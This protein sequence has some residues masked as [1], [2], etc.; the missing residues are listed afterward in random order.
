MEL[1]HLRYFVAV[2]Q[3]GTFSQTA[4]A[5]YVSQSTISEQLADLEQE[6]G[7]PLFD[8]RERRVRLTQHGELFLVEARKVL[9]ASDH[10]M[11]VARQSLKGEIGNL[12]IA[13]FAGGVE[14]QFPELI[15][16]FRMLHPKIRVTLTELTPA[17]QTEALLEGTIDVG[18][19][20]RLEPS[21]ARHLRSEALHPH[22]LVAVLPPEH[23][24][25]PGAIN[26]RAL[27]KERFVFCARETS[28]VLF[29]KVIALCSE[30]G[31][32]PNI[33]GIASVWSGVVM[34]VEAG[35]GVAILPDLQQLRSSN[36]SF[37]PLTAKDAY[38]DL[39]MAWSTLRE[40]TVLKA[41][42]KLVRARKTHL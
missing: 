26:I 15:R 10:A 42:L 19:T 20:R 38:V 14:A 7:V 22:R 12:R 4:R 31:F 13:F 40:D 11:Q 21:S 8:R 30:A 28:P 33:V 9:A 3:H 17:E 34:L 32:S 2:A 1:R 23:H 36:L 39:V 18:F 29:D 37:C 5:V 24:L 25:R 6:L 16:H 41:F 27:R 35:E